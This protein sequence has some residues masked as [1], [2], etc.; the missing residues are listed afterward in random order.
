MIGY[1]Y[2][3]KHCAL[4]PW[5]VLA[6]ARGAV[7]L[8]NPAISMQATICD[9]FLQA[10]LP[11]VSSPAFQKFCLGQSD[12]VCIHDA[13]EK[14]WIDDLKFDAVCL[15]QCGFGS[16]AGIAVGGDEESAEP[17][18]RNVHQI[19]LSTPG[20]PLCLR[21]VFCG[22]GEARRI[23]FDKIGHLIQAVQFIASMASADSPYTT[24][25]PSMAPE[26]SYLLYEPGSRY[27]KHVDVIQNPASRQQRLV[28][29]ILYLGHDGDDQVPYE[30]SSDGGVLRVYLDNANG[31]YNMDIVPK[32]NTLVLFDSAKVPHEVLVTHRSRQCI[33]AWFR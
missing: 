28:S 20:S 27:K 3:Q 17:I 9:P 19:W 15:R 14:S 22:H 5:L 16:Q 11:F 31:S 32:A 7:G 1:R 12:F 30:M 29:M 26:L 4:Y 25:D 6:C 21:D 18:R 33:L 10:K 24:L 23:L 13:F 2:Q 8:A